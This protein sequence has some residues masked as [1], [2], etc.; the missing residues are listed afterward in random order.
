MI[1]SQYTSN[2]G[3][4][5]PRHMRSWKINDNFAGGV[6][7]SFYRN[8]DGVKPIWAEYKLIKALPKRD[9]TKIVPNLSA[10]QLKWLK[11]A[12][13]AGELAVVIIGCEDITNQRQVC[14]VVLTSPDEWENG[15]TKDYFLSKAMNYNAIVYWLEETTI[16]GDYAPL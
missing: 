2:I 10:L 3:K 16:A 12:Q 13:A 4:R 6:P 9:N 7:D 8:L 15:V 5:L 1:E 14:G 11:E